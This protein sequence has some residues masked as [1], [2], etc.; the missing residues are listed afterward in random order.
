[1]FHTRFLSPTDQKCV[2]SSTY[3]QFFYYRP[4]GK[5]RWTWERCLNCHTHTCIYIYIWRSWL[6]IWIFYIRFIAPLFTVSCHEIFEK[7][8]FFF[9]FQKLAGLWMCDWLT[10][11][12]IMLRFMDLG[13]P[14]VF[15]RSSVGLVLFC[16]V[17]FF[18]KAWRSSNIIKT[19]FTSQFICLY[20]TGHSV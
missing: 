3:W 13:W 6:S 8:F 20:S 10:K 12:I 4:P 18:V 5:F 9:N 14:R 11:W 16:F 2:E 1:M 15:R 17:L 7:N 19:Y